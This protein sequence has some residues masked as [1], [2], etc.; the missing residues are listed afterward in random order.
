MKE[1]ERERSKGKK[2]LV[3]DGEDHLRELTSRFAICFVR[4]HRTATIFLIS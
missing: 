4:N 3:V 1:R 2:R